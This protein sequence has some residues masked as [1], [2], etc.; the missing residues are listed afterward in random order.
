MAQVQYSEGVPDVTPRDSVPD[1][2]QHIQATPDEFGALIAQGAQ[3]LGQGGLNA[4]K[5]FGEAVADSSF[6]DYQDFSTK[7]LYGDPN[8]TVIG[9]DGKPQQDLGFMGL[10]GR[11]ALD[12]RPQI[13][14]QLDDH[15]KEVRS[16]LHTPE[17]QLQ[18][19]NFSRRYRSLVDGEIGRHADDQSAKW[20]AD[21]NQ[22]TTNLSLQQ[23]AA[24]PD[25]ADAV[26]HST[27]DLVNAMVKN[28]QLQGGG[29][30]QV[31][32]AVNDG[33]AI[34]LKTQL[35]AI[36]VNDPA[37]AVALLNSEGNRS[38]ASRVNPHTGQSY[39]DEL[40]EQF[41]ARKE[42][43]NGEGAATIATS[44]AA[45]DQRSLPLPT[46]QAALLQQ[47]SG[48]RDN[49]RTSVTGAIG[50]G[51]IEPATFRQYAQP[52]EDINNPN[53]N[54]AVQ[55]R[56][57]ADYFRRYNGD[58]ERVA[59]A[60]YSGPGNV[61]PPGS[62]TPWIR[63][64]AGP[65]GVPGVSKTVASY[66]SDVTSRLNDPYALHAAAMRNVMTNASL[67]DNEKQW[68][69]QTLQR[70]FT[71]AQVA[72]EADAK[73]KKDANDAGMNDYVTGMLKSGTAT[74]GMM[75]G[76][77]NDQRLTPEAKEN[78]YRFAT[79]DF[80]F[81]GT[82]QYGPSYADMYRRI[83]LPADDP[84]R[85]SDGNDI[86]RAGAP[87]GG[88]T[89][90]GTERLFSVFNSSRKDP[91]Q[92]SVNQVKSSLIQ[93]AKSKLSFDQEMLFPGVKPLSDPKGVQI[94][95]AQFVPKFEAAYDAWV[96]GG[97]SPWEFLTQE[98]VDKL[99]TGMRPKAQ[100]AMDR[101][102]SQS[103]VTGEAQQPQPTP[104]SPQGIE[105]KTWQDV[106]AT[107]PVLDNQQIMPPQ[108]W[109]NIL[110]V[111]RRDPAV[112]ARFNIPQNLSEADAISYFNKD[113]PGFDGA[114]ILKKLGGQPATVAQVERASAP[115]ILASATLPAPAGPTDA[116]ANY[117]KARD[118][119]L[120]HLGAPRN[121]R[122]ELLQHAHPLK[123]WPLM[124]PEQ[125]AAYDVE[126]PGISAETA[127][128]V[129]T[130]GPAPRNVRVERLQSGQPAQEAPTDP[131]FGLGANYYRLS[132]T[133]QQKLRAAYEAAMTAGH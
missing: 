110:A 129:S 56:I 132:E 130:H 116:E 107:R 2:Y 67:N 102:S 38:I 118:E 96:K 87:G 63:N 19:D 21:I 95:N 57:V 40:S 64:V 71:Q 11:A 105:D 108:H 10:R 70:S 32:A 17:Q 123:P 31:R 77:A 15:L 92:V 126:Q 121:V 125:F 7:L 39:Y 65:T 93:Y 124:L 61:A 53:D 16:N 51:Q 117:Q 60:Y 133:Q 26:A 47:E 3:R 5:F 52:G 106:M 127:A 41:R 22:S 131:T 75:Q 128:W 1:D 78:L 13:T 46:L 30:D 14:Q 97:K 84:Q 18:F 109:A 94:F 120:A 12:A 104:P 49:A 88:L 100:M 89:P 69:F 114:E 20:F 82:S 23:I 36:G 45:R 9:P 122:A 59:V 98:N 113:F 91:D 44:Q 43:Q 72:A 37:R 54:R 27:A 34:A 74:P 101:V 25:N 83:F 42:K 4:S 55:N 24:T 66:V 68:A 90:R 62:P 58:P 73:A 115:V 99:M 8:K 112:L 28:V 79:Q 33:R 6:N 86:L 111:L 29:D 119:A 35:E 81:E 50:P 48:N 85:I 103:E 80:G 76:I